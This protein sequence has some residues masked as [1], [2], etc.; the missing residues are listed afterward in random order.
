MLHLA[1]SQLG[2]TDTGR[3]Q[4]A[5]QFIVIFDDMGCR[6]LEDFVQG[7]AGFFRWELGLGGVGFTLTADTD[8]IRFK[9]CD[10]VFDEDEGRRDRFFETRLATDHDTSS[11]FGISGKLGSK[12]IQ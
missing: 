11:V 5:G 9:D 10:G 12:Q 7:F 4:H 3:I 1:S 8:T 6:I 2:T